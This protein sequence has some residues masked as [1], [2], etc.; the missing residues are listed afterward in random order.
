MLAVCST[1][2][3]NLQSQGA[4]VFEQRA[5]INCHRVNGNGMTVGPP[6]NGLA[7]RHTKDWVKEHFADPKKLSPGS[8]M[9]A[10]KF[11]PAELESLTTYLFALPSDSN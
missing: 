5:C 1:K 6:L 10:Y 4:M 2:H 8:I 9:P 7:R 3:R 11:S